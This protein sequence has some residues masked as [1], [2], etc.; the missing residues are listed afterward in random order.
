MHGGP[1]AGAHDHGLPA[2]AALE[3]GVEERHVARVCDGRE[4]VELD[5]R[6]LEPA[7]A[8]RER[9]APARPDA[10]GNR[11]SADRKPEISAD[12]RLLALENLGRRQPAFLERGDLRLVEDVV[13]VDL[14][15]RDRDDVEMVHRE[16]AER[17]RRRGA[18]DQ[19]EC[20]RGDEDDPP[21]R[22]AP[23]IRRA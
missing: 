17:M 23:S 5:A 9:D 19:R 13:D 22:S 2:H 20:Q 18:G 21:H 6:E 12:F 3:R 1:V 10:Q 14:A 4:Q 11:S 7:L 16:V 15:C 8:G